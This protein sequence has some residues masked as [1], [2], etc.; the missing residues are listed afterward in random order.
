[1]SIFPFFPS[2]RYILFGVIWAVS[3]GKHHFWLLPNLTEECGFLESFQP[4]YTY[5]HRPKSTTTTQ[6]T[7]D[8]KTDQQQDDEKDTEQ[9]DDGDKDTGSEDKEDKA[10]RDSWVKLTDEEV[11]KAKKEAKM[12]EYQV[13][14]PEEHEDNKEEKTDEEK[15]TTQSTNPIC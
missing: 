12:D 15:T 9:Q 4:L 11:E 6:E 13:Q 3:V 5:E 8:T 2:V 10:D 14:Q 1:M 7:T